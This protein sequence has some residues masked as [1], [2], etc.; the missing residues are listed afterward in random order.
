VFPTVQTVIRRQE[1]SVTLP[2]G[3]IVA[4]L[5]R[6]FQRPDRHLIEGQVLYANDGSFRLRVVAGP[7]FSALEEAAL[8]KAFLLRVPGVAVVVE[9]MPAIP[10][11][12]NGKF[13]FIA[14][15]G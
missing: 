12:P 8:V 15:E 11:G 1:R 5:D 6:V 7:G 3:R 13:E 9:P 10:R 14:L 2:D 4:R